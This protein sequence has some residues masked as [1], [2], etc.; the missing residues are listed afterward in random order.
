[1]IKVLYISTKSMY[2]QYKTKPQLSATSDCQDNALQSMDEEKRNETF[3]ADRIPLWLASSG[4]VVLAAISIGVM[5]Q[6]FKPLKW[7]FVL[8]CYILAPVLAF[9]NAYGSG[10]TDWCLVSTYGK[11]GLFIFSA[12][13]GSHGHGVIAGLA[14]CGVMMVIVGAASDLMQDF[15]TG[16]LTR[17]SPRSMFVSQLV[18]VGM[19]CILAPLTFWMF[20]K[21]FN[22]GDPNGEYKAPFA[23]IFRALIGVEGFSALPTHCLQLC[24]GFFAFAVVTNLVRDLVPRSISQYIPIP[25]AMAIPFY[26]GAYFA[27][28]ML[29]G[30]V[31]VFLWQRVN[32]KRSEIYV[33]AVASG[34][35]CGDGVWSVPAAILALAKVSPPICMMF[36]S[37]KIAGAIQTSIT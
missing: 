5:P 1:M 4:Y 36:V 16:Y 26:I 25:M 20:W 18:G 3:L 15:R 10:L 14:A 23:V 17:S 6:I 27:I 12:W 11:L 30:T 37:S 22:I 28:D 32:R 8:V 9:C 13:A 7:Y 21:A 33:P 34:F 24:Y 31:V 19:G 29:V 35:I 2:Q